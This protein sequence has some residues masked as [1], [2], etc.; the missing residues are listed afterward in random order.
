MITVSVIIPTRNAAVFLADCLAA[1][2]AQDFPADA[3]EIIVVDN[4]S[5]DDTP[6]V[7]AQ[8]GVRFFQ[9]GPE[10]SAQRNFGAAQATGEFLLFLDADMVLTPG[11]V[12]ACLTALAAPEIVAAF[13][14]ER[15]IGDGFWIEVR[16]FERS[17]YHATA[18]DAV[19]FIRRSAFVAVGGYD[20]GL[21]GPED[22]DLDRRLAARG[23]FTLADTHLAHN[24][25]KFAIGRYIRKKAY[26]ARN[27]DAYFAKWGRDAITRRQFGFWY[28]YAGVFLEQGKW[29]RFLAHPVYAL[30]VYW[31]R[32]LVGLVYLR[33]RWRSDG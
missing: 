16:N 33:S 4:F 21:S 5:T 23:R 20:T 7:A 24:E 12:R 31:L 22:W 19:R 13:I 3:L 11:V 32:F 1:V 18:I 30:G 14:P 15:I 2:R 27:F 29:K 17:F 9:H 10:R 28:R 6:A 26:Y 8:P 25:G